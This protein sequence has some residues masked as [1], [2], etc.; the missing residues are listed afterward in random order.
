[1][2]D[3]LLLNPDNA[4]IDIGIIFT[5]I[6]ITIMDGVNR[7]YGK[8]RNK[9][10]DEDEKNIKE[11]IKKDKELLEVL[12]NIE[13]SLEH[14]YYLIR[15]NHFNSIIKNGIQQIIDMYDLE[16]IISTRQE[17]L[18][19]LFFIGYM[20]FLLGQIIIIIEFITQMFIT[21]NDIQELVTLLTQFGVYEL[22]SLLIGGVLGTLISS[23]E[24]LFTRTKN[25]KGIS[26]GTT[27]SSAGIGLLYLLEN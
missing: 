11:N 17:I 13:D 23:I 24:T 15:Y 27:S 2:T 20:I 22:E 18:D 5:I 25:F 7:D 21:S 19:W 12:E 8:Q 6:G 10:Y 3:S 4:I 16:H 1:M 26:F 14:L 9:L